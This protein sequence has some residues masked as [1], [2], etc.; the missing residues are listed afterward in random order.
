MSEQP[1][2]PRSGGI[3]SVPKKYPWK[4]YGEVLKASY[5]KLIKRKKG[6]IK[7]LK[8]RWKAFNGIGING[9]EWQSMIVIGARPGVGKT[10]VA[11]TIARDL[12]ELN[13]DQDFNVLHFQFEMLAENMGIRELS[14]GTGLNIRYIQSAEDDGMKPLDWDDVT[15][16]RLYSEKHENRKEFIIDQPMTVSQMKNTIVAFYETQGRRPIVITIDHT[17]L[18]KQDATERNKQI[19][20]QNLSVMFTEVKNRYPVTFIVLSQLNRTID[21]AERQKPGTLGNYPTEADIYGSDWLMQC[22]DVVI[23]YNRPAKYNL[24]MYGPR[25]FT[26]RPVDKYLLAAHVLKNRFGELSVQWYNAD[27]ATMSLVEADEPDTR[28]K[29]SA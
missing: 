12:Q 25:K 20:L 13:K 29:F 2:T 17:L 21:D 8:T 3:P 23:A 9:I 6:E 27:Y 19:T 10:F 28:E 16:L 1:T 26:I 15:K 22:A 4:Q 5:E 14:A 11:A 18:I 7:S 24:S